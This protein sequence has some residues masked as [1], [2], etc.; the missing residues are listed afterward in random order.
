MS[1]SIEEKIGKNL[2]KFNYSKQLTQ[3]N[4]TSPN[5]TPKQQEKIDNK[6]NNSPS[7]ILTISDALFDKQI[8]NME[9]HIEN[10]LI[11]DPS[12]MESSFKLKETFPSNDDLINSLDDIELLKYF[13]N[14]EEHKSGFIYY[15][16]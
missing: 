2:F 9:E 11:D 6:T 13:E 4:H 10:L 12:I 15:V 7:S 3:H 14:P 5:I 16:K 8:D 1:L